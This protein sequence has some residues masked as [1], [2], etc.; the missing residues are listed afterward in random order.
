MASRQ[1]RAR[2]SAGAR[3]QRTNVAGGTPGSAGGDGANGAAA[4]AENA[5][6]ALMAAVPTPEGWVGLTRDQ[7]ELAMQSTTAWLRSLEAMHKVQCDMTHLALKRH[8]ELQQRLHGVTELSELA[9]LQA[10]LMRFDAAAV[11][12][13]AQEVFD[14]GLRSATEAF[15]HARSTLDASRNDAT[16]TWLQSMQSMVHT[17]VRPLDDLFGNLWLRPLAL[18]STQAAG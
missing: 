10:D 3:A 14:A 7:L 17:G 11:V 1:A 5:A 2:K 12:H 4:V 16:K 8:Q 15:E 9:A 6:A 18:Q 13:S